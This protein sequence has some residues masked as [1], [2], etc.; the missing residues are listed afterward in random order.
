M[1]IKNAII[2]KKVIIYKNFKDL[3][4]VVLDL[5]FTILKNNTIYLNNKIILRT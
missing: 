3:G 4:L 2:M 5:N 1:M